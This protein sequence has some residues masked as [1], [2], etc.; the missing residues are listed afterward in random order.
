MVF[1]KGLRLPKSSCTVGPTDQDRANQSGLARELA[2]T[3]AQQWE[4]C[5][6]MV[7]VDY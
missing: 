7:H 5:Y 6:G 2:F 1:S 3:T 4:W